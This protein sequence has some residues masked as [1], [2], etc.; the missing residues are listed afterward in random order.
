MAMF[1][2]AALSMAV[3]TG[4][5]IGS[6]EVQSARNYRGAAQVRAAAESGI[7]HALQVVN[8]AGATDFRRDVVDAWPAL[9][10]TA[11]VPFD[12]LP[13]FLYRVTPFVP[14]T[15]GGALLAVA[16]GPEGLQSAVVVTLTGA[17][18][19]ATSPGAIHLTGDA[20][21]DPVL[22]GDDLVASG[23][24]QTL[25]GLPGTG[26]PVYGVSTRTD[27]NAQAVLDALADA[28]RRQ[29]HGRGYS[30]DGDGVPSVG[31]SAAAPGA[32]ALDRLVEQLVA[33]AAVTSDARDLDTVALGTRAAPQITHLTRAEVRVRHRRSATGAGIL[34]VDGDL[35]VRGHLRFDG[36]VL[37][38]AATTVVGHAEGV[39]ADLSVTGALWTTDMRFTHGTISARYSTEALRFAT[40]VLGSGGIAGPLEVASVADCGQVPA[41]TWGCP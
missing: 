35:D 11:A 5:L 38:R 12:P 3:A 34:L 10:G 16:T 33:R 24:D 40:A 15:G 27:A 37:V 29:V 22:R 20:P 39:P 7:A 1:S 6:V 36:L 19:P 18:L 9:W 23:V 30:P 4:L 26:S 31:A 2:V 21:V 8:V 17:A 28:L 41:G 32:T 13:D 14:A 25:D